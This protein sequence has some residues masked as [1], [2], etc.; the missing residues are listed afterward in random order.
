[1]R[2]QHNNQVSSVPSERA[3]VEVLGWDQLGPE[4]D[5]TLMWAG[6]EKGRGP[7]LR[8]LAQEFCVEGRRSRDHILAANEANELIDMRRI[9]EGRTDEFPGL[10]AQIRQS[11]LKGPTLAD[12]EKPAAR[13]THWRNTFFVYYLAGCLSGAG[14]EVCSVDGIPR[15]GGK[16]VTKADIT[17]CWGGERIA[18]EC[19]RPQTP[20]SLPRSVH[21]GARQIRDAHPTCAY[22]VLAID[23]SRLIRRSD[24][25]LPSRSP[26]AARA[27]V[28]RRIDRDVLPRVIRAADSSVLG[29][30]L[31][32]RVPAAVEV[33]RSRVLLGSGKHATSHR[34][35]SIS[36]WT[37]WARPGT[38]LSGLLEAVKRRLDSY[39][40]KLTCGCD[41]A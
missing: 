15:R 41:R 21:D 27:T 17:L 1:M 33:G 10:L 3:R 16:P 20:R 13:S 32:A 19:K 40:S 34:L 26:H 6:V 38:P 39:L 37:V 23:C 2:R 30:I 8:R 36:S 24:T 28:D 22:G 25:L 9:W 5:D 11:I 7:R 4:L 31:P 29:A 12:D 18:V 35:F 14:F